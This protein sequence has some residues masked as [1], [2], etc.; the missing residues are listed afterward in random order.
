[1]AVQIAL[2]NE[3]IRSDLEVVTQFGPVSA[4]ADYYEG[5]IQ[6]LQVACAKYPQANW[7]IYVVLS[8]SYDQ[9]TANG[10]AAL[11]SPRSAPQGG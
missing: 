4:Q 7:V 11:L 6:A 3:G 1:M 9:W 10:V 2:A 8:R 5:A